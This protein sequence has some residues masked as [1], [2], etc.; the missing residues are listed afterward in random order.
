MR[1]TGRDRRAKSCGSCVRGVRWARQAASSMLGEASSPTA[2]LTSKRHPGI[3]CHDA[4]KTRQRVRSS[5]PSGSSRKQLPKRAGK[6]RRSGSAFTAKPLVMNPPRGCLATPDRGKHR[7][8]ISS[9]QEGWVPLRGGREVTSTLSSP[10]VFVVR[11]LKRRSIK[12]A[13]GMLNVLPRVVHVKKK[14]Q[15]I[16]AHL[17]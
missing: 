17:C 11:L 12:N 5:F 14:S 10:L 7:K 2:K 13:L 4:L 9:T 6:L 3:R 1:P 16:V 8:I 15:Y